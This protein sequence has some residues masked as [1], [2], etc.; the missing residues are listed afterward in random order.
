M[1]VHMIELSRNKSHS[2][3]AVPTITAELI[4]QAKHSTHHLPYPSIHTGEGCQAGA[5][6]S[7]LGLSSASQT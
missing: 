1:G 2:L 3:G 7:V 4:P 5:G 6:S